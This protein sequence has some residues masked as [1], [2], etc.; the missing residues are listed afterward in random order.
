MKK[1]LSL[2]RR[3]LRKDA[4]ALGIDP[5]RMVVRI[6]CHI[7]VPFVRFKELEI[8]SSQEGGDTHVEFCVC[9]TGRSGWVSVCS[10]GFGVEFGMVVE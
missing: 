3:R 5:W 1:T 7:D 2:K 6:D 9:E 4:H 8:E 10:V